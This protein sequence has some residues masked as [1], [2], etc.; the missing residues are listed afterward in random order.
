MGFVEVNINEFELNPFQFWGENWALVTAGTK[1]GV[2]TMTVGWGNVGVLWQKK[3]V[4]IY[5]RPQRYTKE[6]VDKNDRFSVTS[7]GKERRE[8]LSYLGKAS[9]K[10]EDKISKA[11]LTVEYEDGVPYIGE[12]NIIFICRKLY[13]HEINPE[14]FIDKTIDKFYPEKDYHTEYIAEIEK[15]LVKK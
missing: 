10:Q 13:E 1:N 7:F 6:F 2:N 14:L 12:G 11:G 9:G 5:I 4:S 3:V 15:I 8:E